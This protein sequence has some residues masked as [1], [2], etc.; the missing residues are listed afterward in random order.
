MLGKLLK[1]EFKASYKQLIPI[2]GVYLIATGIM[3]LMQELSTSQ[4]GGIVMLLF[5]LFSIIFGLLS[6]AV[7]FYPI[8]SAVTRFKKNLLGNEG[9]LMN[10][11]PVKTRTH[12]LT[13]II[14]AFV[15]TLTTIGASILSTVIMYVGNDTGIELKNMFSAI[16]D[17]IVKGLKENPIFVIEVF[18]A[19]IIG[20][21][22]L[23]L[24]FYSAMALGQLSNSHKTILSVAYYVG[25]FIA[26]IIVFYLLTVAMD[27]LSMW[28]K[29]SDNEFYRFA[30]LFF[31]LYG[32]VFA[33]IH[34][35]VTTTILERRLNLE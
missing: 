17:P 16:I 1:F 18:L 28:D 9:Y 8:Y 12:I 19:V 23:I 14:V 6:I 7:S 27:G 2:A 13:K 15:V 32:L 26:Q 21:V 24:M 3:R 30:A 31:I 25:I 10:T 5:G 34:Y 4:K 22:M 35:V 29:M 20:V 11:L 33:I